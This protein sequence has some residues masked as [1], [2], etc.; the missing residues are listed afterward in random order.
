MGKGTFCGYWLEITSFLLGAVFQ[1]VE[2]LKE[3]NSEKT[4]QNS[5]NHTTINWRQIRDFCSRG[6]R[7]APW[8][9]SEGVLGGLKQEKRKEREQRSNCHGR[10][11]CRHCKSK[12]SGFRL[13]SRIKKLSPRIIWQKS[14]KGISYLWLNWNLETVHLD[15]LQVFPN[16]FEK[17]TL[18]KSTFEKIN[19]EMVFRFKKSVLTILLIKKG[20]QSNQFSCCDSFPKNPMS[21]FWL[22][23]CICSK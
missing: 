8:Y 11:Q 7:V 20:P 19:I 14:Q 5:P 21:S 3:F 22:N 6:A 15:W 12:K 23:L 4:S 9:T 10:P 2:F 13:K 17:G 18:L 16:G 1:W